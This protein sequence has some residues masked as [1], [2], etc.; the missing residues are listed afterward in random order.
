MVA[1]KYTSVKKKFDKAK[2]YYD[3]IKNEVL[4]FKVNS[5]EEAI[6]VL[7]ILCTAGEF[8]GEQGDY[9]H[10]DKL[11]NAA[12]DLCATRHLVFFLARTCL[13]LGQNIIAQNG[14][15]QKAKERFYDAIAFGRLNDNRQVIE[16]AQSALK[17]L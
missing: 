1:V 2:H 16:Y 14:D 13:R 4:K 5:N 6:Q 8:Y 9:K 17:S 15:T 3:Q 7:S 12:Y 11:L 10:S